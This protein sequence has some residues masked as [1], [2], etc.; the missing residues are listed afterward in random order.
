MKQILKKTGIVTHNDYIRSINYKTNNFTDINLNKVYNIV[1]DNS[2]Y[3]ISLNY[4][5][6]KDA[7]ILHNSNLKEKLMEIHS[8][9]VVRNIS[10]GYD[11]KRNRVFCHFENDTRLRIGNK[12]SEYMYIDFDQS[13]LENLLKKNNYILQTHSDIQAQLLHLGLSFGFN[14]KVAINDEN[15]YTDYFNGKY[16]KEISTIKIEDLDI[17]EY[18]SLHSRKKIDLIDVL[19]TDKTK[20]KII[21]AFEIEL[22][23]NYI[24]AF[25]RL[26]EL[27]NHYNTKRH[28][29]FSIIVS[30][31]EAKNCITNN[32]NLSSIRSLFNN[33]A[34]FLSINDLRDML[35]FKDEL[36][37]KSHQNIQRNKFFNKKIISINNLLLLPSI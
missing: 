35:I 34:F 15:K 7:I 18:N 6:K 14:V 25:I 3:I 16:L 23:N 1:N 29:I 19:W 37:F 20:N 30:N 32:Y 27:L 31:R 24:D 11:Q 33:N 10:S 9:F 22:S 26:G 17:K 21:A 36:G 12:S 2:K 4:S 5:D 13:N 8:K 28:K